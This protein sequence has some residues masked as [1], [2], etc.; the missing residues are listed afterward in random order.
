MPS[1]E[2]LS[3]HALPTRKRCRVCAGQRPEIH[4]A[5]KAASTLRRGATKGPSLDQSFEHMSSCKLPGR[6]IKLGIVLFFLLF[7]GRFSLFSVL[8]SRPRRRAHSTSPCRRCSCKVANDCVDVSR[9][10]LPCFTNDDPE[11]VSWRPCRCRRGA[12]LIPNHERRC[13]RFQALCRGRLS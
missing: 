7:S 2:R 6:K 5:R 1:M 12:V 10:S 11:D 3:R 4:P 9:A 13:R 8:W